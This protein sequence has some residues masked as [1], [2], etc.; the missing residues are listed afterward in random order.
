MGV[1]GGQEAL[2]RMQVDINSFVIVQHHLEVHDVQ[3]LYENHVVSPRTQVVDL[4]VQLRSI[5]VPI[6]N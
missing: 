6:F 5:F 2:Q 3:L 1:Y 4:S